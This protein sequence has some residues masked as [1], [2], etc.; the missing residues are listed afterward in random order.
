[1]L[2]WKNIWL[3]SYSAGVSWLIYKNRL[4]DSH[5]ILFISLYLV[6]GYEVFS[7]IY[8]G[9]FMGTFFIGPTECV[10]LFLERK[11][12]ILAYLHHFK[13]NVNF[14]T[15]LLFVISH[16]Q[17]DCFILVSNIQLSQILFAFSMFLFLLFFCVSWLF[18]K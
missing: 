3:E 15:L 9:F 11:E 13:E 5:F 10:C 12:Y 4:V 6:L 14:L 2:T 8:G 16:F 17:V 7:K 18:F 1:M